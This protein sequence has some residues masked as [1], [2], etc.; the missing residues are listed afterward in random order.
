MRQGGIVPYLMA[1][2]TD[3]GYLCVVAAATSEGNEN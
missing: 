1:D 3:Y 2:L